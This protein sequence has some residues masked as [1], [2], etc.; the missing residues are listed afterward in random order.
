[1]LER[2]RKTALVQWR[3][4]KRQRSKA[5]DRNGGPPPN[6]SLLNVS[7]WIVSKASRRRPPSHLDLTAPGPIDHSRV[8]LDGDGRQREHLE[9][10]AHPFHPICAE[11]NPAAAGIQSVL[12]S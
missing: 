9:E 5:F 12:R 3:P 10:A 2:K 4:W 11:L 1:M 6:R 7:K 8:L